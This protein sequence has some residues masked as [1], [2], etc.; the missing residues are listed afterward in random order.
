MDHFPSP[1]GKKQR[2]RNGSFANPATRS[3]G[4]GAV[5]SQISE[6]EKGRAQPTERVSHTLTPVPRP[7]KPP[8]TSHVATPSLPTLGCTS[9]HRSI[10]SSQQLHGIVR[11]SSSLPNRELPGQLLDAVPRT[12]GLDGHVAVV[13]G[14][15]DIH[16]AAPVGSVRFGS[17]SGEIRQ[18]GR[19]QQYQVPTSHKGSSIEGEEGGYEEDVEEV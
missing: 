3:C 17:V 12:I 14:S 13:L 19:I 4:L 9:Q 18:V 1:F 2:Q 10:T 7:I 15:Q 5:G 16:G 11:V 6:R 8:A